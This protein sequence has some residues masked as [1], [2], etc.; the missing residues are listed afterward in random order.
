[1]RVRAQAVANELAIDFRV[2]LFCALEFFDDDHARSL[3]DDKAVAIAVP[4]SRGTF[5]LVVPRTYSLHCTEPGEP[6]RNDR[7]LGAAGEENIGVTKFDHAPGFANSVVR[8]RASGNDAH[9]RS[10]QSKFHREQSARHV[11][12]EHWNGESGNALWTFGKQNGVLIF[13]RF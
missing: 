8:S 5:R 7:C 9:V 11:A 2:A 12:D 1:M 4:R 6:D 10:A 13:E 3:A